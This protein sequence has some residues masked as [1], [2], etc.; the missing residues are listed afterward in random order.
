MYMYIV[1]MYLHTP[2]IIKKK[3]WGFKLKGFRKKYKTKKKKNE[4][5]WEQ[6][7]KR[8]KKERGSCC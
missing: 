7:Q 3:Q 1:Q 5:K 4:N 8:K 6:Q 2:T